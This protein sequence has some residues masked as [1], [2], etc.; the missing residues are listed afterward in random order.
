M[1]FRCSARPEENTSQLLHRVRPKLKV[2]RPPEYS[3]SQPVKNSP[4]D[5]IFVF[6]FFIFLR[7]MDARND[8]LP[9]SLTRGNCTCHFVQDPRPTRPTRV[10]LKPRP[11]ARN[12]KILSPFCRRSAVAGGREG[13]SSRRDPAPGEDASRR[14]ALAPALRTPGALPA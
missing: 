12:P 2:R 8:P 13:V 10:K 1:E 5:T 11:L 3:S 6:L 9:L 4:T 7:L 14:A